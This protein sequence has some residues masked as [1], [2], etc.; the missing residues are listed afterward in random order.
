MATE[1]SGA[2]KALVALAPLPTTNE[3]EMRKITRQT[4]TWNNDTAA[5]TTTAITEQVAIVAR[6]K[7][8]LIASKFA[9]GAAVTGAA[10]NFFTLLI[11]KRPA[12]APGTPV[13]LITFAADTATTDDVAA[14]AARDLLAAATLAT[15]VPTAASADFD[16]EEGD[17]LTVAV[18]KAGTGMTFPIAAVYLS[19][20]ARS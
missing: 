3:D 9:P 13:N 4:T 1:L 16:L 5:A 8:R 18:T 20:E 10:T 2:V 17:V 14:F 7:S 15:Y 11:A 6:Q 19:L 12:S